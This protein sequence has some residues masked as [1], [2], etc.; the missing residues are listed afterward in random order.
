[1]IGT[2]A[3]EISISTPAVY[4]MIAT[5]SGGTDANISRGWRNMTASNMVSQEIV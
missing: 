2:C 5:V 1:M 4:L 3:T